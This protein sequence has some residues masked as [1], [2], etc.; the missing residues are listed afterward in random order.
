MT[1]DI[2]TQ[3]SGLSFLIAHLNSFFYTII[4]QF[5]LNKTGFKHVSRLRDRSANCVNQKTDH[6]KLTF[7]KQAHI[8]PYVQYKGTFCE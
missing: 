5:M 8:F 2:T 7:N 1:A 4:P 3:T 6:S